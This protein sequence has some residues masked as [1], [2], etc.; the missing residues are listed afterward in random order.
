MKLA[1]QEHL[2]PGRDLAEKL[3]NAAAYGFEG[4]E[5]LGAGLIERADEV[6]RAFQNH[7]LAV[8]TICA[9]FRGCPLSADK[10]ER[11][12]AMDDVKRLLEVGGGL[13]AVGL[14]FVPVFGGPKLPDLSP[15]KSPV[16][17]ELDL[18]VDLLGPVADVA[19]STGCLLLL[20]PLNRYETHLLR[21]LSDAVGVVNRVARSGKNRRAGLAVMADF[22]HMSIEE[23]DMAAALGAAAKHVR[24]VHLADSQRLQP[25]TGHTD[26]R[27]G[28]RALKQG[29][30]D[31]FMALECGIRGRKA[32]ALPACVSFL[33]NQ[34]R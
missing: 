16:D 18:L 19:A 31:D 22:F 23:D 29:G 14:I 27:A 9:G 8:S 30:F 10:A 5:L 25:G 34:L 6:A 26:F 32:A 13:G 12:R 33:K 15:L 1:V 2:V 11:D 4:I 17:L 7:P 28:F 24:H 3:D 21:R 20:E